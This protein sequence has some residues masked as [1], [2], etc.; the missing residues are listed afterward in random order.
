MLSGSGD[1]IHSWAIPVIV[2]LQL[3]IQPVFSPPH[4]SSWPNVISWELGNLNA[5]NTHWHIDNQLLLE[6]IL[7]MYLFVY[8][9]LCILFFKPEMPCSDTFECLNIYSC[10]YSVNHMCVSLCRVFG[11]QPLWSSKAK[12]LWVVTRVE[13]TCDTL[14]LQDLNKNVKD[15]MG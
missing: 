7:F 12:N 6:I 3:H 15:H 5:I 10:F 1:S 11:L 4:C 2:I 13:L 9:S 8:I 14:L